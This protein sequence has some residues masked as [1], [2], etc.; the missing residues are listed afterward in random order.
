MPLTDD[1]GVEIRNYGIDIL[2][3]PLSYLSIITK[4]TSYYRL[5]G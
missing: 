5:F 3:D 1:T 4:E 2:V